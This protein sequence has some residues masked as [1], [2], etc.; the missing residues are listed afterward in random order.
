MGRIL[1]LTSF[2]ALVS[3]GIWL[4]LKPYILIFVLLFGI[5]V[6]ISKLFKNL[7]GISLGS[8]NIAGLMFVG[9]VAITFSSLY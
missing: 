7:F 1:D 5:S 6:L 2:F 9:L 8:R 3:E 4:V